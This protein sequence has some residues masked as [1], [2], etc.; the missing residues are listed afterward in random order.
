MVAAKIV[1]NKREKWAIELQDQIYLDMESVLILD[2][3][4]DSGI[5]NWQVPDGDWIVIAFWSLPAENHVFNSPTEET[6]YVVDHF[7]SQKVLGNYNYL[8]GKRT[9]LSEFYGAPFRAV[10]NDS[11]EFIVERHYTRNFLD[12]FKR[13]RFYDIRPYLASNIVPSYNHMMGT[14]MELDTK[15]EYQFGPEDWRIRYDYDLTISELLLEDFF[16]STH[17]WASQRNLNHRTQPYGMYMDNIGAAGR[18]DIPEAEQLYA[19]GASPFLKLVSSGGLLYNKPLVSAESVVFANRAYMTTPL[20]VKVAVDKAFTAGINHIIYHGTAYKYINEDFPNE[21]W[22]PWSTPYNAMNNFSFDYKESNPFWKDMK[23]VNKY[24]SRV[25]YA[26]QSGRPKVDVLV[27]FPFLG[28]GHGGDF[29]FLQEPLLNGYFQ[30]F[31]PKISFEKPKLP[32]VEMGNHQSDAIQWLKSVYEYLDRI[33]ESGLNWAW[34]NNESIME[35]E[36]KNDKVHIR[37]NS[38]EAIF[39]PEVPHMPLDVTKKIRKLAESGAFIVS[40]IDLPQKQPGFN[41][42]IVKDKKVKESFSKATTNENFKVINDKIDLKSFLDSLKVDVSFAKENKEIKQVSRVLTDSSQIIFFN[43]TS[44]SSNILKLDVDESFKNLVWLNPESGDVWATNI[45]ELE[46]TPYQSI[47]LYLSK[48]NVVSGK[49]DIKTVGNI[50][51]IEAVKFANWKIRYQEFELETDTLFDWKSNFQTRFWGD[52]ATYNV[53]FSLKE[54]GK[55]KQYFLDLGELYHSAEIVV[56]GSHVGD[57]TFPPYTLEISEHIKKGDNLLK[58]VV[59]TSSLNRMIGEATNGNKFYKQFTEKA[60]ELMHAGL[61]GP[62]TVQ[63]CQK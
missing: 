29:S 45:T 34:V 44:K 23:F 6:T 16:D 43:N 35:A 12:E 2:D 14:M 22:F 62:V 59:A 5:L 8:F 27:Y 36:Y 32:F 46:L 3:Y 18:A 55:E 47:V 53:I 39:L 10:F 50:K 31:E 25:Q 41:D 48:D 13:R 51:Q 11:Y 63:S 60:D 33:E 57:L 49:K 19:G 20:K 9:G 24:V 7:D 52:S 21:G 4:V 56:N 30:G 37:G 38:F 17:E 58:I 54:I 1:E 28:F 42:Y 26:L 40:T 61:V 15:P